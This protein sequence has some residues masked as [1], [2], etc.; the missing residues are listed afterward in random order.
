[1]GE[2]MRLEKG[3][4][5]GDAHGNAEGAKLQWSFVEKGVAQIAVLHA[6]HYTSEGIAY[7]SQIY[8]LRFTLHC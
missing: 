4:K 3:D 2:G 5:S 7:T 6:L 1:M 8:L